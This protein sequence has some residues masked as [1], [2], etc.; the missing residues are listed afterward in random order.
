MRKHGLGRRLSPDDRDRGFLM[1]R[2]LAPVG[3]AL[4][5]RKTWRIA[6]KA[7]DQ[8]DT[9]TCVG[10]AWSNFLRC[11]PIQTTSKNAPNPFQI[12]IDACL[13][14]EWSENDVEV[15]D[16]VVSEFQF[17]TSVRAGAEAVTAYGRLKSYVWSWDIQT[18]I[19]WLR[20][21]G[22]VVAGVNWYPSFN[23]PDKEGIVRLKPNEVPDGGH[24]FCIRGIDLI[25]SLSTC[26]QSWGDS[27]GKSGTFYI[28]LRDLERLIHEDGEICTAIEQRVKAKP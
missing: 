28:P 4:P 26:E 12:Y 2:R 24:A 3:A 5:T 11:E 22:P 14:D 23:R 17:G 9:G 18:T 27:W 15:Q 8:G 7:L 19:D 21:N 16:A 25:R 6:S 13:R 1:A 10:H 20:T